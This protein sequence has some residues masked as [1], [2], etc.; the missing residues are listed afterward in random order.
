MHPQ[1]THAFCLQVSFWQDTAE[2]LDYDQV[3]TSAST[4]II[5]ERPFYPNGTVPPLDSPKRLPFQ[6]LLS[7]ACMQR[8]GKVKRFCCAYQ[9]PGMPILTAILN[10]KPPS[11]PRAKGNKP[12]RPPRL[13]PPQPPPPSPQR[14]TS[15]AGAVSQP[16][17]PTPVE[18]YNING[19][20]PSTAC[21]NF[22]SS[23]KISV[24]VMV[25]MGFGEAVWALLKLF[26]AFGTHKPVWHWVKNV[27]C[28]YGDCNGQQQRSSR[29]HVYSLEE[30]ARK[31]GPSLTEG[32][33]LDRSTL[34]QGC[35]KGGSKALADEPSP[36]ISPAVRAAC[37]HAADGSGAA[38]GATMGSRR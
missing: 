14:P 23:E 30:G 21:C 1:F 8:R 28:G 18:L 36:S 17:P 34:E 29:S 2:D 13:K 7:G 31:D 26:V 37:S 9:Q 12:P 15:P 19:C 11:P 33:G 35:F 4:C 24:L 32:A 5:D 6:E 10:A 16:P 20:G 22:A 25:G 3:P 38:A 27:L